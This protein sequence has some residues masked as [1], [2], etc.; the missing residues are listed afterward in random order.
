MYGNALLSLKAAS[1]AEKTFNSDF[2]SAFATYRGLKAEL[3]DMIS[4]PLRTEIC[5]SSFLKSYC[6]TTKRLHRSKSVEK[7]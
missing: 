4:S 6:N 2:S 5:Y 3:S 7:V 1:L